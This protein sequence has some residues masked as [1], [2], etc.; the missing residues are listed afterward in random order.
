MSAEGNGYF[1]ELQQIKQG[2]DEIRDDLSHSI[3]KLSM[4][5]DLLTGEFRNFIRVAENSIPIKAVFLMFG[6]LVLALVGVEGADW[7]FKSYLKAAQ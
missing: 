5:V 1:K 2:V 4:S 3:D 6:I 7:L